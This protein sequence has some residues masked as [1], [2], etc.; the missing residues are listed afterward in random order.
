MESGEKASPN[1]PGN[2]FNPTSLIGTCTLYFH[3]CRVRNEYIHMVLQPQ[4]TLNSLKLCDRP[5]IYWKPFDETIKKV[6]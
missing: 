5:V 4:S 1:P 3:R 6:F 2:I